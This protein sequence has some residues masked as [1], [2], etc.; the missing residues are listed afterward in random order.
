MLFEVNFAVK[1]NGNF[2]NVHKAFVF[3]ESVS[4]CQEKSKSIR[5]EL[6]INKNHHIH[7]FIEA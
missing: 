4:D 6:S 3:A 5:E 7:I 2:Q 1:I